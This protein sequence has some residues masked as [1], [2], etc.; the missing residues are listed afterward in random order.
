MQ[1][2]NC[3]GIL[4]IWVVFDRAIDNGFISGRIFYSKNYSITVLFSLKGISMK[5]LVETREN[6][7]IN[8]NGLKYNLLLSIITKLL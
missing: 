8:I 2:I 5:L 1:Y 6:Q 4:N 3:R 7:K